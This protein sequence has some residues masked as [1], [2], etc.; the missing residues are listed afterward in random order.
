MKK[1][2]ISKTYVRDVEK[3]NLKILRIDDKF[4]CVKQILSTKL[5]FITSTGLK[6][7]DNNYQ[8]VEILPQDKNYAMRVF[9]D[10]KK[11][12]I[13]RYFDVTKQN[14]IDADTNIPFYLDLY[15]D[16][17]IE[18]SNIKVLDEAELVA[19]YK[20]NQ[21]S[22][23]DYDLAISTKEQLL[24]ELKSSENDLLNFNFSKYLF[25]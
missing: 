18:G 12:I 4:V 21:I 3:F 10:D 6:L 13:Q 5:P 2:L 8:I 16:V 20:N 19:A 1:K 9:V 25:D 22:K 7:I 11:Q 14:S 24:K 15:L 17:I 23:D